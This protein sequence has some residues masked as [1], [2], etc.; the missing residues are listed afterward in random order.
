MQMY[1]N[2]PN[3]FHYTSYSPFLSSSLL[4]VGSELSVGFH[5]TESDCVKWYI[6]Q[7]VGTQLLVAAVESILIV[8]GML[9][10]FLILIATSYSPIIH[11]LQYMRS[12]I[13]VVTSLCH[14]SFFSSWRTL[15]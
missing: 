5:Y 1:L 13:A 2:P 8:R 11:L 14:L 4:F 15:P 3:L 10:T 9:S 12:T 6:F 7:E